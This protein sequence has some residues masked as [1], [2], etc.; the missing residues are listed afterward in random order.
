MPFLDQQSRRGSESKTRARALGRH[1]AQ[2]QP[3]QE[4]SLEVSL[5][6][7]EEAH[8]PLAEEAP[9]DAP[10]LEVSNDG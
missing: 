4:S 1:G 5:E 6:V 8:S 3:V 2:V 9:Q 7:E 10:A